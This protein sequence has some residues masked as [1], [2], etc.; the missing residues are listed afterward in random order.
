MVE[1]RKWKAERT[2]PNFFQARTGRDGITT[3]SAWGRLQIEMSYAAKDGK[4]TVIF[5][6]KEYVDQQP[7]IEE[8]AKSSESSGETD[9]AAAFDPETGE[10]N[11]DC[12]CKY[13]VV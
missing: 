13:N 11:W 3:S 2:L 9:Q 8:P 1:Y 6:D 12:P 10:I 7:D 5:V 4:D